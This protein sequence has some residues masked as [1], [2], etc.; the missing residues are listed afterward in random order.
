MGRIM[1]YRGSAGVAAA[2]ATIRMPG[3][4]PIAAETTLGSS[5]LQREVLKELQRQRLLQKARTYEPLFLSKQCEGSKSWWPVAAA[6][7][8]HAKR[9]VWEWFKVYLRGCQQQQRLPLNFGGLPKSIQSCVASSWCKGS[10]VWRL[11]WT[12]FVAAATAAAAAMTAVSVGESLVQGRTVAAAATERSL[13]SWLASS[14]LQ[15]SSSTL[16]FW[17][18]CT[19]GSRIQQALG[20]SCS[21]LLSKPLGLLTLAVASNAAAAAAAATSF[22]CG[23]LQQLHARANSSH[24]GWLETAKELQQ[25][26]R[27]KWGALLL[28]HHPRSTSTAVATCSG[29]R[30]SLLRLVV[31]ETLEGL[32]LYYLLGG[33]LFRL[34]PSSLVAPGAFSQ[35]ALSLA[36][37]TMYAS[38]TER[39]LIKRLGL[40]F[41]CHTCGTR[42]S[43]TRWVAD[44]QPPTAQV[45]RY[46]ETLSGRIIGTL[47]RLLG[48]PKYWPQRLYPQC[49][50]CSLKQA[51]AV[52]KQTT[53]AVASGAAGAP[54][55]VM[56]ASAKLRD[57]NM[58]AQQQLVYRWKSIRLWH[59]TG[60]I[61]TLIRCVDAL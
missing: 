8:P 22:T 37:S 19:A 30:K 51:V 60:G 57:R 28:Q 42:S 53:A 39:R 52:R 32:L 38:E 43:R 4:A 49:E 56:A 26:C 14:L 12:G 20:V 3:T 58:L 15:C 27:G 5:Q 6:A 21:S 29:N 59:L 17:G 18:V 7:R 48:G 13:K 36:A 25:E 11:L 34:S 55:T 2:V 33:R 47:R 16:S 54:L 61:L 45:L 41:G 9:R 1:G 31:A 40:R 50:S 35:H 24:Q 44:H 23:R 46:E 10:S